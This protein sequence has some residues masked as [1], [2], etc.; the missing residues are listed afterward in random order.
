MVADLFA[1]SGARRH[2]GAVARRARGRCSSSG[3][4][5]PRGSS[6]RTCGAPASRRP[7]RGRRARRDRLARRSRR[8]GGGRARSTSCSSTRPT[9]TPRRCAASLELVGPHLAPGRPGRR[10]A[11][12]ARRAAGRDRAASIRAGA[13]VRR[14]GAHLLPA[15]AGGRRGVN[16][17]VYP[18]SF[19]P[20]TN[21]HLDV[22]ARA[23]R[24]F[25]RVVVAVLGNPRKSP[26]LAADERVAVIGAADRRRSR[27]GRRASRSGRSTASRST[28]AARSAPGSSSAACGRSPTSR[29]S[30]SSPTTTTSSRP[31]IDTVFFMTS[32]EHSYVSSSLVKEIA[33][34]RRR[35]VRDG[36]A[37]GRRGAARARCRRAP[38]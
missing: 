32:L 1:G 20:I 28:S 38:G 24:V 30:S 7:R 11:L 31:T 37:A 12:L 23:A 34:V 13:A 35:R 21:G 14:D 25:D 33:T 22:I 26:L 16:V 29:P 10:Q 6:P 19:D 9:R 18:G 2:R 5:A 17:A 4:P 27:A 3:T 8:R 36:A 15:S